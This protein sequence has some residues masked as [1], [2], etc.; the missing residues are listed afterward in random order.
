VTDNEVPSLSVSVVGNSFS[1]AAGSGAALGTVTRTGST[2]DLSTPLQVNITSSDVTEA[3]IGN[4]LVPNPNIVT[5]AAGQTSANFAVNAVDDS[6]VDGTQSVTLTASANNFA[7]ATSSFTV[8]DDDVVVSPSKV[9]NDFDNDQISDIL[10]RNVDSG[11]VYLYQM[12][13]FE[14]AD[15]GSLRT[16]GSEWKISGTGDFNA[17]G[18]SDILWRNDDGTAYAWLMNENTVIGE[19]AIRNLSFDWKIAGTGD[20]NGDGKS[21][22]VWRNSSTQQTYI[23]QMDG[24][25]VANERDV[26]F[27]SNDWEII[28][29][30]GDFNA[31]GKSDLLWRNGVSGEAY[32]Y[33]MNGTSIESESSIRPVNGD[34]VIKGVDDF[35]GDGKSDILWRNTTSGELYTYQMDGLVIANE[36]TINQSLTPNNLGDVAG[37]GDYNG[38]SRA[39]ILWHSNSGSSYI[40]NI[41]GRELIGEGAI[42]NNTADWQI[43]A[44]T[45]T[46][47]V[48]TLV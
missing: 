15:E 47:Y 31:D 12:N 9:R 43:A 34:W 37:T 17:D 41:D 8:T 38:D 14:I 26:R 4:P 10:W 13:G 33:L 6:I 19:T 23:Y 45:S 5:I 16:V 40:W 7:V 30:A 42:R 11:E 46:S 21:D 32:I 2:F 25:L 44:P 20:F 36:G 35:D 27:V 24:L 3:T 1:E 39:D 18:N 28:S 29:S 22:I 48:P